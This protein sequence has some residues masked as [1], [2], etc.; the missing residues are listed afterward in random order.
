MMVS[1]EA[2]QIW[3]VTRKYY[4]L[5]ETKNCQFQRQ[6]FDSLAVTKNFYE[7]QFL[8]VTTYIPRTLVEVECSCDVMMT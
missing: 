8:S 1:C 4:L 2:I 5:T 7:K 3:S 6:R